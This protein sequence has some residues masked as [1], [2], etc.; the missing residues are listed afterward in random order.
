MSQSF[1]LV[2]RTSHAANA[3]LA[4]PFLLTCLRRCSSCS[5]RLESNQAFE[6]L[7]Q[8]CGDATNQTVL[9]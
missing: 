6:N 5:I 8:V 2:R 3:V 9:Q 7:E 4:D 1:Q